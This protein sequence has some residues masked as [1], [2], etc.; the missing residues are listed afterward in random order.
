M[1][2]L[3]IF[4]IIVSLI[5]IALLIQYSNAYSTRVYKYEIFNVGNFMASV[6]GYMTIYFGNEWYTQALKVHE[7][8][9]NGELLMGSGAF[10]LY[11]V[12]Y[13]NIERTAPF[14]GFVMSI[15]GGALYLAATPLVFFAFIVAV[16]FFSETKPVYNIND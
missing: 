10:L 3:S 11:G 7:D 15:V 6:L 4:G 2:V 5:L 8:L 16:A 13:S 12:L 1:L 14:Y 9:L